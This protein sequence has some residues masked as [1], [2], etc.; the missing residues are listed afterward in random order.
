MKLDPTSPQAWLARARSNLRRAI[1]GPQHPEVVLEDLVFDAQQ[2]AE[3]AL[4]A[5]CLH[6]GLAFPK[7]HSLVLLMDLVEATGIAIPPEVKEAD[8]LTQYAVSTRYPG[9]D[10]ELNLAEYQIAVDL[11][12]R[13]VQWAHGVIQEAR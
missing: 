12:M 5:V 3:K 1:L 2:A 10:E 13:L 9:P 6:R 8:V 11:A 7:T 4:K